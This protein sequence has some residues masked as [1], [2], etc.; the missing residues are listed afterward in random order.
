MGCVQSKSRRMQKLYDEAA[1]GNVGGVEAALAVLR[2]WLLVE[3]H[4]TTVAV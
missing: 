1:V 2:K 3:D 4:R